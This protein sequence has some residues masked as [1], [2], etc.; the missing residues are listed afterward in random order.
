MEFDNKPDWAEFLKSNGPSNFDKRGDTLHAANLHKLIEY[1]T[2]HTDPASKAFNIA[3][4]ATIPIYTTP[5]DFLTTLMVRFDLPAAKDKSEAG[6]KSFR[7]TIQIPIYLRVNDILYAWVSDYFPT[8]V[9]PNEP[10]VRQL[11]S[12]VNGPFENAL[13]QF[14]VF[15]NCLIHKHMNAVQIEAVTTRP[16]PIIPFA[17]GDVTKAD[18]K[19]MDPE[20]VARQLCLLT[21]AVWRTCS[22]FHEYGGAPDFLY[23]IVNGGEHIKIWALHEILKFQA[24]GEMNFVLTFIGTVAMACWELG[25]FHA[26]DS[27]FTALEL[28][29][30]FSHDGLQ[31]EWSLVDPKISTWY[32]STKRDFFD[33]K[34]QEHF[35]SLSK[36]PSIP[37]S[38][39]YI[40]QLNEIQATF[41]NNFVEQSGVQLINIQKM[42]QLGA[43]FHSITRH[44]HFGYNFEPV[45]VIQDYICIA[46]AMPELP[47]PRPHVGTQ[48]SF[49]KSILSDHFFVEELHDIVNEIVLEELTKVDAE[50]KS[51]DMVL[52]NGQVYY[53]DGSH[54]I[55]DF[56]I[57]KFLCDT[58]PEAGFSRW[59]HFDQNC[60]VTVSPQPVSCV[61]LHLDNNSTR[62]LVDIKENFTIQEAVSLLKIGKL[63]HA[64]FPDI[65]VCSLVI[66]NQITAQ[67][68]QVAE[69]CHIKI[70]KHPGMVFN[71]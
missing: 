14:A 27:L 32:Y 62:M 47:P 7:D 55:T 37:I 20:E 5:K 26:V 36:L 15:I 41:P 12:F 43:V 22:N 18:I 70:L 34:K 48:S 66:A 57:R 4:L 38:N 16:D 29:K 53:E 23:P 68:A 45:Q 44:Q 71:E 8:H 21:W 28:A 19:W 35:E 46:R 67:A 10:L 1:M 63:Y 52:G 25:N 31:I 54:Y 9:Q 33:D 30:F 3:M 40:E 61:I 39:F 60:E 24:Q 56:R 59:E 11:A 50:D 6:F 13:P 64:Q 69:R 17:I 51:M 42:R 49:I 65:T 2:H 58:F